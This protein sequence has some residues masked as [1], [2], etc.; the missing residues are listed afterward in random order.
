MKHQDPFDEVLQKLGL[1]E[2]IQSMS[3]I[4]T[5]AVPPAQI[6][7]LPVPCRTQGNLP[8]AMPNI[9]DDDWL[10]LALRELAPRF[11]KFIHP[12]TSGQTPATRIRPI[13]LNLDLNG[14]VQAEPVHMMLGHGPKPGCYPARYRIPMSTINY[15]PLR[16]QVWRA[17][18][19][20]L[21]VLLYELFTRRRIFEGLSD[22]EFQRN[23]SRAT[24]FPD[25]ENLPIPLQCL[26]Y[27]CWSAEFGHY[28]AL[29]KIKQYIDDNPARFALQVT[30]AVIGAAG[31]LAV[32]ILGAIGFSALG[33]VAGSVAAGWQASIGAV[34]AGS[35]FAICQSAAMG[36]AAAAGFA[37]AG[38]GGMAAAFAALGLPGA[39]SVRDT[40]IR[41]FRTGP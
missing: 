32:P 5:A 30:G 29:G 41:K 4:P 9:N 3:P 25:L 15:L 7:T 14:T 1:Y 8:A 20:A 33:P 26:I 11:I 31:L 24:T 34:E 13:S 12:I 18:K 28:I 21:G 10:D 22:D 39:K 2:Q 23:Y 6:N 16:E 19:F 36:G 27:T 37:S 38:A 17:E 40:F 35:L